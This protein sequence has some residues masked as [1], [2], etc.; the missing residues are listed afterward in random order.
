VFSQL[1]QLLFFQIEDSLFQNNAGGANIGVLGIGG[2]AIIRRNRFMDNSGTLMKLSGNAILTLTNNFIIRQTSYALF[3]AS[4]ATITATNNNIYSI[5][6]TNGPISCT[7]ITL[8]QSNNAFCGNNSLGIACTEWA[9]AYF[10][11]I[12][13]DCGVCQGDNSVKDCN[14]ICWGNSTTC[15]NNTNYLYVSPTES[16]YYTEI[17]NSTYPTIQSAINAASNGNTIIL[18]AGNYYGAGNNNLSL[19]GKSIIIRS[20]YYSPAAVTI[21]CQ[22]AAVSAFVASNREKFDTVLDSLTIQ[23]CGT[24]AV[25]ISNSKLAVK[26]CIIKNNYAPDMAGKTLFYSNT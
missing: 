16:F 4:G 23:N 18:L 14:G 5:S 8:T 7:S 13:D 25:Y 11:E 20:Q 24:S 22:N 12:S 2:V 10:F 19:Q 15:V 21:D 9:S 3:M 17:R 6:A 1:L 26:N